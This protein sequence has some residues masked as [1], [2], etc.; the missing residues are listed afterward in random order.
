MPHSSQTQQDSYI[1]STYHQNSYALTDHVMHVNNVSHAHRK[2]GPYSGKPSHN[3]PLIYYFTKMIS[4]HKSTSSKLQSVLMSFFSEFITLRRMPPSEAV[5]IW[6]KTQVLLIF[7]A[8][9]LC[10]VLRLFQQFAKSQYCLSSL[11]RKLSWCGARTWL[12]DRGGWRHSCS[13]SLPSHNSVTNN[14]RNFLCVIF[15]VE[16]MCSLY[17][18]NAL[19]TITSIIWKKEGL[20]VFSCFI[21]RLV[22]PNK[23]IWH[24]HTTHCWL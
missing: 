17:S 4:K 9:V 5:P 7:C 18:K 6:L 14:S 8:L 3:F 19:V 15:T 20:P 16:G 1:Y 13:S 21:Y 12:W 23:L 24:V 2:L 10:S 22:V 11:S